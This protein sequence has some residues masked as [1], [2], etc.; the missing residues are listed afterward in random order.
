MSDRRRRET[1]PPHGIMTKCLAALKQA[2]DLGM[3]SA[4]IVSATGCKV[5]SVR[6]ALWYLSQ[7]GKATHVRPV[8]L[9]VGDQ[10]QGPD[11][12]IPGEQ[13]VRGCVRVIDAAMAPP[14]PTRG[15]SSVWGL[16]A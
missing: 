6:L 7:A 4:D 13:G 9:Y 14:P 8:W 5:R 2:G 10:A 15:I 12:L 16:A 11:D 1:R 3:S